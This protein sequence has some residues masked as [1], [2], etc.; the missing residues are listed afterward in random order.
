M[1]W[2]PS[3]LVRTHL[4]NGYFRSGSASS[5]HCSRQTLLTVL[6]DWVSVTCGEAS[7]L[8]AKEVYSAELRL[9]PAGCGTH[10]VTVPLQLHTAV[11]PW[12]VSRGLS[13]QRLSLTPQPS[14][15][16]VTPGMLFMLDLP[17]VASQGGRVSFWSGGISEPIDLL[18]FSPA[19][20]P[21]RILRFTRTE[22]EGWRQ[23]TAGLDSSRDTIHSPSLAALQDWDTRD[24]LRS[25]SSESP[26]E[27]VLR[28]FFPAYGY[29]V[30]TDSH[31][32]SSVNRLLAQRV[33]HL[34]PFTLDTSSS[35]GGKNTSLQ[36]QVSEGAVGSQ[37]PPHFV[38]E[39]PRG[40]MDVAF[41]RMRERE[42]KGES[43]HVADR[44][45]LG[46]T[47]SLHLSDG[48]KR[49][50][51]EKATLFVGYAAEL[52]DAVRTQLLR[53][54]PSTTTA[55]TPSATHSAPMQGPVPSFT[56]KKEAAD[57]VSLSQQKQQRYPPTY[58]SLGPSAPPIDYEVM[59]CCLQL[60]LASDAIWEAYGD[61][62]YTACQHEI[63]HARRRLR[64][65]T[66]PRDPVT[67]DELIHPAIPDEHLD[68]LLRLAHDPAIHIPPDLTHLL[69]V[70][71]RERHRLTSSSQ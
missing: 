7:L 12:E 17:S 68:Q 24:R 26:H 9:H 16:G 13:H 38:L 50:L 34:D 58:P 30:G 69:S 35:G 53:P 59:D 33:S 54:P 21:S 10:C 65:G 52:T 25:R 44:D 1:N 39:C 14:G 36:H 19:S 23:G 57:A 63:A 37:C 41:Q 66:L 64:L 42:H 5:V 40:T 27:E 31:T 32:S 2:L 22:G 70:V 45:H 62:L 67:S 18:F 28:T 4:R 61:R 29:H 51:L 60:G 71:S 3:Q 47:I 6:S 46:C 48:L 8:S 15:A 55:P 20:A 56:E 49:D 43:S 11:L